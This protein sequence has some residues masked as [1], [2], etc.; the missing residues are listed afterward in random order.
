M[1]C[2]VTEIDWKAAFKMAKENNEDVPEITWATP[3]E[4]AAKESLTDFINKRSFVSVNYLV[5]ILRLK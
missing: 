3:G 1:S 5:L 4:D 2:I